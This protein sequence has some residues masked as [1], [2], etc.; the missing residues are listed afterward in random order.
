MKIAKIKKLSK[1]EILNMISE[2][3]IY[4]YYFGNFQINKVTLN[5]LRGDKNN[6]A[7][8]IKE[9]S[10]HLYHI[11]YAVD[12]WRGDCFSLVQQMFKCSFMEALK[13]IDNDFGLGLS[14][15][16]VNKKPIDINWE[17]PEV[18]ENQKTIIQV[19]AKKFTKKNLD[20]WQRYELGLDDLNNDDDDIK[21]YSIKDLYINKKLFKTDPDQNVFGYLFND[22]YWKIYM[23]QSETKWISNCPITTMYGLNNIKSCSKSLVVKSVK[24]YKVCKKFLTSCTAGVQNESKVSISDENIDYLLDNS[25]ECFIIFDNDSVGVENCKFYNDK[26][27]KYWNIPKHYYNKHKIKDPSDVVDFYGSKRLIKLFNSRIKI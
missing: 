27:F 3:D 2:Y 7:F 8:E 22:E 9:S 4:R 1:T 21:I 18:V 12:Y 10:G 5:H 16:S 26:G 19:T 6:P 17:K 24:D 25:E 11:D 23:P 15:T 14:N 20:F 13:I